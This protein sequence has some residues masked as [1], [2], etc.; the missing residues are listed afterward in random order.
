LLNSPGSCEWQ[1]THESFAGAADA[2]LRPLSTMATPMAHPIIQELLV[3][4]L[5]I[6]RITKAD[7]LSFKLNQRQDRKHDDVSQRKDPKSCKETSNTPKATRL[8]IEERHDHPDG[9]GYTKQH[10]TE[11]FSVNKENL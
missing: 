2:T 5:F 4:D 8:V 10:Q 1:A 11:K 9:T 7:L 3:I 6:V